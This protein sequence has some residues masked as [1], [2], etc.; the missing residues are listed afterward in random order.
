[1]SWTTCTVYNFADD[2]LWP[3]LGILLESIDYHE[4]ARKVSFLESRC[5]DS[6]MA[7]V[8]FERRFDALM[9]YVINSQEHPIGKVKDF[10]YKV[11]FEI[12]GS[13]HYLVTAYFSGLKI[14]PRISVVTLSCDVWVQ[15]IVTQDS[16]TGSWCVYS[17]QTPY[18]KTKTFINK[19]T[20]AAHQHTQ[21]QL[22]LVKL[23]K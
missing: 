15:Y 11:E 19:I 1:M 17:P 12:R 10:I 8:H 5:E 4:A 21:Y 9:K 2:L 18:N 13:C 16:V 7:A 23:Y 3:E 22:R 20:F 6:L 14:Y